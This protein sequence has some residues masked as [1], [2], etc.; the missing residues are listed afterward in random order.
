MA[1]SGQ[2]AGASQ[3]EPAAAAASGAR[4]GGSGSGLANVAVLDV[5]MLVDESGSE[6]PAKVTD[7]KQTVGTI[8]QSMLNP[9][10]RVTVVG[11]GGVNH[12]APNQNPVDV[13]CQPTIA[14]G[15][16]N[17]SYL[18]SCVG[19]LH[20]RT[21]AQGDDTDYAAALGQAMGYLGPNST[22]SPP[23]PSGAIKV[24]L[25]MT[26]G[27]VD[28]HRDTQQYGADWLQGEQA[29]VNQQ[30]AAAKSGGVQV[31]PLGFGT[32]IG[33]GISEAQA[34]SYLNTIAGGAAPA[35]CDTRHVANQP[36]ATWVNDPSDA[37]S[38]L[39]QL[40]ADA[41][42]LGT[43]TSSTN[44][45]GGQTSELSLTIPDIASD[46]VISVDRGNPSIQVGFS[47]PDGQ[48]WTDSS[49]I[50]GQ[51]TS[52][53][54]VLHVANITSNEVGTWHIHLTAPSGLA[55]RLVSATVFWQGAVRA[56]ITANPPSAKLGQPISVTLSVLGPNGPITDP[57]TLKNLLVGV[58]VSGDDLSGQVQV[59]VSNAG[60]A[61]GSAGGVGS[62]KGTYTAPS[63]SGTLTFTG[64]AA[65]YGLYATQV[66][67]TVAVGTATAG[68]TATVVFPVV[69]SV[70][71][72]SSI[73]GHIVFT[74]QTGPA[75][76]VRL[77]LST[78][79]TNA[80]ITS[81][82]GSVTVPSGNPPSVPFTVSF[83]SDSPAG[84]AWLEVKAVDAA[85][86][87][88]V[89]NDATLNLTVTKPPGFLA[90]YLWDI[91]GL[92]ALIIL[93][94]LAALW[95]RS[96]I[97]A[98][99]DVRGL[100]VTLRRNGDQQGAELKA[101]NRWSDVFRFVIKDESEPD[102]RLDFPQAGYREYLVRRSGP[103]EV[104]LHTPA[105]GE[106]YD[107]VVGGPGEVMDH[108]GLELAFREA[109]PRRGRR[110]RP[111][112]PSRPSPRT[113]RPQPQPQPTPQPTPSGPQQ[114]TG[115]NGAN[116]SQTIPTATPQAK[117]P[118]DEWL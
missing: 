27:A 37:I 30:L 94:V 6:T 13:V 112:R 33:T 1:G 22:S 46:A 115:A 114:P 51:D 7:E 92:I 10:S 52:P 23:S 40:Y 79:G 62:Y 74:N 26:D 109:R 42:C 61:A 67:A 83:N 63:Q 68:F 96:V 47:L 2:A 49:A 20:R 117:Q 56:L 90:K 57:A 36:H 11:F 101:P 28:V 87:G 95:R 21:E 55:S 14:G 59:P 105:G 5:V 18:A 45:T 78:S 54:E 15:A 104:K 60:E 107:V 24:I 97:R 81:P 75:K 25:M 50:S 89:Y 8:V 88:T 82:N 85:N 19:G 39:N 41:A 17:L 118:K 111:S 16:A 64:T 44:V 32:D 77:Q 70:Q 38:A 66:P 91:I 80:S 76:Q 86:S 106:P 31:W 4:A 58:T 102:A 3:A 72:G 34:L 100:I 69:T 93:A 84:S 9:R 29:A 108:N 48:S 73:T 43:S 110:G 53:V 35:V 103:T 98:R 116:G 71:A 99:K 65:G 12:V 113:S